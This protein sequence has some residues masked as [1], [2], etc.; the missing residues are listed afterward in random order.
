VTASAS[1]RDL[2]P[3][4]L[5]PRL[6]RTVGFDGAKDELRHRMA[7]ALAN[8]DLPA[9][10][11]S[12]D[13]ELV[14]SGGRAVTL[15]A[16]VLA[17][18]V[19]GRMPPGAHVNAWLGIPLSGEPLLWVPVRHR[20][21]L[22]YALRWLVAPAAGAKAVRNRVLPLLAAVRP[23]TG[24]GGNSLVAVSREPAPPWPIAATG[25]LGVEAGN[26]L[27]V[28]S[29]GDALTRL[30]FLVF[31]PG[32]AEPRW[33]VKIGRVLGATATFD[34][35]EAGLRLAASVPAVARH[36][37]A[38]AG[39][40]TA[41]GLPVSVESAAAGE[42]VARRLSRTR[43]RLDPVVGAVCDWLDDVA[44]QSVRRDGSLQ[45]ALAGLRTVVESRRPDLVDVIVQ[46]LAEAADLPA[47]LGH[48][49][50]GTW[51]IITDGAGFTAVDWERAR[52][53]GF[54]LWDLLYFLTDA[55]AAADGAVTFDERARHA[56]DLHL[57]RLPASA[58]F[59]ER[60]RQAAGGLGLDWPTVGRLAT[61]CWVH[62]SLSHR[63]RR[64]FLSGTPDGPDATAGIPPAGRLADAWLS[65]P[66]LAPVWDA[67]R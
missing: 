59:F 53:P 43:D 51:N 12:S 4:F 26:W 62:H 17:N 7:A 56:V 1:Q 64:E 41:N 50:L 27:L 11:V 25:P 57:G 36:A 35:D 14:V 67:G 20:A 39:R 37:P 32:A 55:L 15:P 65:Q 5:L 23:A 49:D 66:G 42:T 58:G 8:A 63:E 24:Y 52:N 13:A 2:D 44:T 29:S 30:V 22:R 28:R 54:P 40:L 46:P 47:V 45:P 34:R 6:P 38:S 16:L 31:P 19:A 9:R 18:R 33:A 3:L 61:L 60:I 10:F 48:Y 21:A